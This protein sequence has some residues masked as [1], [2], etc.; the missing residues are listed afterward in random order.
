ME[1]DTPAAI[2]T[3]SVWLAKAGMTVSMSFTMAIGTTPTLTGFPAG[4]SE[5]HLKGSIGY[6]FGLRMPEVGNKF[7]V[8]GAQKEFHSL[9][10]PESEFE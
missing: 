4:L 1:V 3:T 7:W 9:D 2:G 8:G 6:F 5:A 10:K